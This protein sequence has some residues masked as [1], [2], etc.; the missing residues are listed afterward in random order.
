M[1]NFYFKSPIGILEI[2]TEDGFLT[3]LKIV[4]K[5]KNFNNETSLIKD[6]KFQ[7]EEYFLK[8]RKTFDIKIN[9]KGTPFQKKVWKELLK[10]PYGT[11]KSYFEIAENI[12]HKNANRAVGGAC[13]KNPIMIII[14]CHRVIS[15]NGKLSGFAYGIGVKEKLLNM[16][17]S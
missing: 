9:P 3:S 16:E 11:T 10:I 8:K 1:E 2:T 17:M 5:I 14:P 7:L 4:D 13:N 12:E 6:I 15:K